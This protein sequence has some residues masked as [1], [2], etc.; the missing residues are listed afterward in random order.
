MSDAPDPRSM[1]YAQAS[2][3][4]DD[5]V[6][7]FEAPEVDVDALVAKL[8]RATALV[9][10]LDRRLLATKA[11]VDELAPRLAQA[12]AGTVDPET[13]EVLDA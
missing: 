11:Q 5:I 9:D 12:G 1:S 2:D 3:E 6:A 4:L 8:E 10:E 13:G 7:F